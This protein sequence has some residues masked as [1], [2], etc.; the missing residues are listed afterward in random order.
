VFTVLSGEDPLGEW[1]V[2]HPTPRGIA[3]TGSTE[4]GRRVNVA[5]ARDLK[6]VVLELGGNDAAIVLPDV[7]PEE[8][9]K[10]LFWTAFRFS[11]QMCLGTKR[12]YL[13]ESIF[14]ASAAALAKIADSVRVGNG[15]DPATEIG[16]LTN[17]MQFDRVCELVADALDNGATALA[18]GEPIPGPGY[19]FKPTIL[20]DVHDDTRIVVEEQFGPVLPLLS[21]REVDEAIERANATTYGLGGSVWSANADR[22]TELARR[23]ECGNAWVNTH[24]QSGQQAPFGGVKHSGLGSQHGVWSLTSFT[25]AQTVWQSRV[26]PTTY[27]VS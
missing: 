8:L 15:L 20:T 7:D 6:R 12:V 19:F 23:L 25:D 4:T 17:R 9:A 3:F 21:Y 26:G 24:A 27:P 2:S 14:E 1:V 16:P 5:A 11:G 10:R 22:A 13:H 18:G